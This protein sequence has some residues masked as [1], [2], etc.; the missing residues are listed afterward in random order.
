M[1]GWKANK[2]ISELSADSPP[3]VKEYIG[4]KKLKKAVFIANV[5]PFI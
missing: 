4:Q 1:K 2:E 3:S 5:N